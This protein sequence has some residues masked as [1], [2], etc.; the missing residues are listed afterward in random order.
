MFALAYVR[1]GVFI[2]GNSLRQRQFLPIAM[3]RLVR[4]ANLPA[5]QHQQNQHNA[6]DDP[7]HGILSDNRGKL[8]TARL[9]K[10]GA[11]QGLPNL[12]WQTTAL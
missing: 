10:V 11:R 5:D 4:T 2:C 8:V 6:R 3:L 9:R 12:A 7:S 1:N